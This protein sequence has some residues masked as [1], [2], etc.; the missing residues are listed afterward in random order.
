MLH[1]C[2]LDSRDAPHEVEGGEK[3]GMVGGSCLALA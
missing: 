3:A 2:G 1:V